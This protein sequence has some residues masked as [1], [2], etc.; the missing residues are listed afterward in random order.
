[1]KKKKKKKYFKNGII[2]YIQKILTMVIITMVVAFIL[3]LFLNTEFNK[4]LKFATWGI[5][6]VGALSL[7]GSTKITYSP[8]YNYHKSMTGLTSN[9]K[10][11]IEQLRDSHSFFIFMAITSGVLYLGSLLF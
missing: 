11:D 1:M 8:T 4:V 10:S 3:S 2:G 5:L 6:T 9:T 7:M